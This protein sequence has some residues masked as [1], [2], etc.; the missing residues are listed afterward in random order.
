MEIIVGPPYA[1]SLGPFYVCIFSTTVHQ[2]GK[3]KKQM[4]VYTAWDREGVFSHRDKKVQELVHRL[5]E[6]GLGTRMRY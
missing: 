5:S 6:N 4:E 1:L 2:D 3:K